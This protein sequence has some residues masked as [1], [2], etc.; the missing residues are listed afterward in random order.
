MPRTGPAYWGCGRAC[1][2]RRPGIVVGEIPGRDGVVGVQRR[3]DFNQRGGAEIRPRELLG[4]RPLHG[5]RTARFPR[6]AG[7]FDS[8][9]AGVLAAEASAEVRHE[10][11][12]PLGAHAARLRRAAGARWPDCWCRS[13]PSGG[14]PATPPRPRAVPWERAARR[15]PGTSPSAGAALP[16]G[17]SPPSL[18]LGLRAPCWL[19]CCFKYSNRV[20]LEGCSTVF[21]CAPAADGLHGLAGGESG[22]RGA[23]H[24]IA[25]AHRGHPRHLP[26]RR[27]SAPSSVAP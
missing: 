21:H 23:R 26:R 17:P 10:D 25:L 27:K 12:H 9:L 18:G 7:R 14:H 24:E 11:A 2:G 15:P 6:Q 19:A 5:H 16:P 20:S 1:P 4:A 13:R 8:R 3:L 22:G